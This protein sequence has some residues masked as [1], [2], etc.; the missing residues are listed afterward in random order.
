VLK[1]EEA[2]GLS[3]AGRAKLARDLG[4]GLYYGGAAT[5]PL[6]SLADEGRRLREQRG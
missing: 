1:A 6:R 5:N 3:P 2:L 4:Q